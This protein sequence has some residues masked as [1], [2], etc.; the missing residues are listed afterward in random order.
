[1]S[2]A[3]R[4]VVS[5]N[6]IYKIAQDIAEE[7]DLVVQHHGIENVRSLVEKV[8]SSLEMLES[9]VKK[10]EHLESELADAI[11]KNSHLS[12][13][14][15]VNDQDKSQLKQSFEEAEESWLQE[16]L[17]LKTQISSLKAENEL[18]RKVKEESTEPSDETSMNVIVDQK[19]AIRGFQHSLEKKEAKLQG[20]SCNINALNQKV[21]ELVEKNQNLHIQNRDSKRSITRLIME[22]N[23]CKSELTLLRK[24]NAL[25]IENISE[26]VRCTS[27]MQKN[28]KKSFDCEYSCEESLRKNVRH[29]IQ[30]EMKLLE[31]VKKLQSELQF[32]KCK[33]QKYQEEMLKERVAETKNSFPHSNIQQLFH[34]F[35]GVN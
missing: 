18:L 32:E 24:E 12:S 22:K 14:K 4:S 21:E 19:N 8:I 10:I 1:M 29:H 34:L 15:H 2:Y 11:S 25:L 13:L 35:L 33:S 17:S 28:S 20:L 5:V 30:I 7:F 31:K 27:S 6:D 3:E 16:V 26:L 23:E 9:T